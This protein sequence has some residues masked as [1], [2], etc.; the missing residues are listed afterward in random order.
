MIS[1][2]YINHAGLLA[3]AVPVLEFNVIFHIF[4]VYN[5]GFL[6]ETTVLWR[7]YVILT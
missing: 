2:N 7:F 6:V 4:I 3:I 1:Q 5:T